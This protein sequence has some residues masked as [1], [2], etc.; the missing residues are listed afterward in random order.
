MRE[1]LEE[2]VFSINTIYEEC[3]VQQ[4]SNIYL[5]RPASHP[6]LSLQI[7]FPAAYPSSAPPTL[8]S[9]ECTPPDLEPFIYLVDPS[10][11]DQRRRNVDTALFNEVL[12]ACFHP[13]EV[14]VFNFL[15]E[16][17]ERLY[18]DQD[19]YQQ[20]KRRADDAL[21][22]LHALSS[23]RHHG[24]YPSSGDDYSG[25]DAELDWGISDPIVDRKST[26]VG[27]A[28]EVHS[29]EEAKAK[30]AVLKTNKKIQKASH[31]MTAWRIKPAN[32][33]A[34]IQ[35]CDDDGESAAGGRILHLLTL[36]DQWNVMVVVSRWFGGTHIGPDRFK[37]INNAARDALVRGGFVNDAPNE[38]D[39][40]KGGKSKKK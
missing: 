15:D 19:S 11:A 9:F 37:H 4:A 17:S 7:S 30:L 29:T 26:F 27:R 21:G 18:V 16:L 34:T 6:E 32:G 3:M 22:R 1:E 8:L 2:E 36:M 25:D 28:I 5:V 40:K 39:K 23:E 10:D 13:G 24:D 12:H 20:R 33:N 35:D 38:K 14:C 31:N